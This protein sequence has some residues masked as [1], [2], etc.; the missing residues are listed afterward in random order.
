MPILPSLDQQLRSTREASEAK[1]VVSHIDTC[2]SCY[3]NDHHQRD[4]ELLL[5][6][7]VGPDSTVGEVLD[8]VA[9][10]YRQIGWELGETRLGFDYDA[11]K[12]AIDHLK[13]DNADR[14]GRLFDS[15]LERIP[16][17]EEDMHEMCQAWFLIHWDV[18][19]E[20]EEPSA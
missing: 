14:L 2:L 4:G 15:S 7:F 6:V 17:G 12:A 13:I 18:P 8:A 10:E 3:L 11:A 1:F 5:G 20:E 9:D 16:E 19:E